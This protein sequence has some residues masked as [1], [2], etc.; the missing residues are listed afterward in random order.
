MK[1]GCFETGMDSVMIFTKHGA[2][3]LLAVMMLVSSS[4]AVE[5]C[6]TFFGCPVP[7]CIGKWCCD[8]YRAKCPPCVKVPLCFGCDDYCRK[9]SPR[10]CVPLCFRCDDY[11]RKCPPPVCRPPLLSSVPCATGHDACDCQKKT[12]LGKKQIGH[13]NRTVAAKDQQALSDAG[14]GLENSF[15]VI[16]SSSDLNQSRMGRSVQPVVGFRSPL[17][18]ETPSRNPVFIERVDR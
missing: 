13:E 14:S 3:A 4:N 5:P 12:V 15:R 9:P 17:I 2:A 1:S 11:C 6:R 18:P 10:V 8:D 7:D 16:D